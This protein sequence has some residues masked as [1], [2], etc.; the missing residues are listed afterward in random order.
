MLYRGILVPQRYA[1]RTRLDLQSRVQDTTSTCLS[2]MNRPFIRFD[3]FFGVEGGGV[4]L[5]LGWVQDYGSLDIHGSV[6]AHNHVVTS[7][8][9]PWHLA[10][11]SDPQPFGIPYFSYYRYLEVNC[12]RGPKCHV[13]SNHI[14]SH[15]VVFSC[16]HIFFDVLPRIAPTFCNEPT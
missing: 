1:H 4:V 6:F 14:S 3:F 16:L 8:Y 11:T 7:V 15:L 9:P 2:S 5:V 12:S 13:V 10:W